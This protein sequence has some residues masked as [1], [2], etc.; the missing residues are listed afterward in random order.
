MRNTR[1]FQ[2]GVPGLGLLCIH[3]LLHIIL[4]HLY[5]VFSV[6][7]FQPGSLSAGECRRHSLDVEWGANRGW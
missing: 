6:R 3:F 7:P 5:G 1:R 2:K 4:F